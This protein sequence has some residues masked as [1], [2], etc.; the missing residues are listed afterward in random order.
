MRHHSPNI[1]CMH[2]SVIDGWGWGWSRKY[3]TIILAIGPWR[4][5]LASWRQPR[6]LNLPRI[7]HPESSNVLHWWKFHCSRFILSIFASSGTWHT[8]DLKSENSVRYTQ[9]LPKVLRPHCVCGKQSIS[10]PTPVYPRPGQMQAG[11]RFC[12][13]VQRPVYINLVHTS[14]VVLIKF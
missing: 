7:P 14:G 11:M 1:I 10:T 3:I 4:Q 8:R 13:V 5:V 12:S 9:A 2:V 6:V